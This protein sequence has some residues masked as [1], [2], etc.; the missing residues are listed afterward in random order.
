[1]I[2]IVVARDYTDS[3]GGRYISDG[4]YSG[5]DFREKLLIPK[6]KEALKIND[7]LRV[8]LDGCFGYPSSFI[9]EAFG[10]LAKQFGKEVVLEHLEI[11]S[12]D[13]PSLH[14]EIIKDIKKKR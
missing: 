6:F 10:G 8:N 11:I 1:M 2:E 13:Q 3:P 5:E 12:L 14:E 7:K 4:E 9:D